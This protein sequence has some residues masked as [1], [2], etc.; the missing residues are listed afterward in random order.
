[1]NTEKNEVAQPARRPLPARALAGPAL[2]W[3]LLAGVLAGGFFYI[4]PRSAPHSFPIRSG[5][6]G[7]APAD[8][9][10]VVTSAARIG[11]ISICL[12]GLGTVVPLNT[13]VVRPRVDGELVKVRYQEG[14][15][16]QRGELLAEI[17]PRPFQ[18]QLN[19]AE[20]Q[21]MRD[22][23][24]L[25]N[26]QLNLERYRTLFNKDAIAKQAFDTQDS[27]VHQYEGAVKVDRG[28]IDNANLQLIYAHVTAPVAGRLGLRQV[29]LGNVVHVSD[30]NGMVVIT[31]L[32]PVSIVFTIPED[33][34]PAVMKRLMSG[35]KLAVDAYDRAQK[36]RIASGAVLTVDNQIDPN[37]GAVKLKAQFANDDF[38]L[39]PNQFVNTRLL[40]DVKHRVTIVPSAGI[41]R[42][43]QDTFV[44]VVKPDQTVTV[45]TVTLGVTE[46]DD[47][48][49]VAGLK[50]GEVI[51]VDGAD[52][53]R[54]GVTVKTR[55]QDASPAPDRDAGIAP[56]AS[57]AGHG[58]ARDSA[59]L[60]AADGVASPGRPPARS[61]VAH[62]PAA[63]GT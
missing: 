57:R 53:L 36:N 9:M 52:K 28:Q 20:G 59:S 29:D 18:I 1:M 54:E 55:R 25:K 24:L 35:E 33:S 32:K 16:V 10:R 11:D 23:A 60:P 7:S 62:A 37:S 4:L 17:D 61:T 27:L 13:V 41:Q 38:S 49:I 48:E 6:P 58:A 8:D 44:Y 50:A 46:G 22:Q 45:R 63:G 40:V 15:L 39:F 19:Q 3:L 34:I 12:N 43:S 51:V 30:P 14:K 31:Q 2:P 56:P 26:S 47:C 42:G 5:V 21:L